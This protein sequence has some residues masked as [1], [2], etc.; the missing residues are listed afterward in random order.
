MHELLT[1]GQVEHHLQSISQRGSHLAGGR[2]CLG[3]GSGLAEVLD[4]LEPLDL[5]I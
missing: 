5:A 2:P 3:I 1:G 4:S